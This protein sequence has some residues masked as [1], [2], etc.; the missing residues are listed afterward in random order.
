MAKVR[1]YVDAGLKKEYTFSPF[2]TFKWNTAGLS[3]GF[4]ILRVEAIGI[5]GQ[6]GTSEMTINV[7]AP[8]TSPVPAKKGMAWL[9]LILLLIV[10]TGG[11]VVW[12]F[13]SRK[14]AGASTATEEAPFQEEIA[15]DKKDETIFMTY[16]EDKELVPPATVKVI[17]SLSLGTGT[18]FEVTDATRI[19]RGGKN[20]VD[21]PDQPVSR[22]H[23]EIYFY[24]GTFHIR[25]LGSRNGIKVD[26]RRIASDSTVLRS[27]AKIHF[28]PKTVLEFQCAALIKADRPGDKTKLYDR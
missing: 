2:D 16:S 3:S 5:N 25:D 4:H 7:V 24:N 6:I 20:D 9:S 26:G 21:I 12:W 22:N 18:T 8:A 28:G 19:G 23:A 11:V 17:K 27:G 13:F 14:A 10:I 1:Y 15:E